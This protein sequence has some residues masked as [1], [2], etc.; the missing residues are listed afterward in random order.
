MLERLFRLREHGTTV[1]AE[2]QA[3]FAT[4]L[5]LAYI[6]IVNPSILS[7][8]GVPFEGALFATCVASA[9]ATLLMGV[10]ANYPFAL[11][12]GMGL[13]AYFAYSVVQ[14][15]GVPWQTALGAVF[16]SG[17][18]FVL[19]TVGR[20]RA[21]VVDAVP[22][23]LK[24]ATAAG[25][26]LFIAFIGLRNA[27]V[28]AASPATFVT[29]GQIA[30][31]ATLLSLAGLVLTA[32]LLARGERAA[33]VWGI[34]LVAAAAMALRLAPLPHGVVSL[35]DASATFLALDVRAALA[36]GLLDIVFVFLFVDLFDSVGT[37]MGLAQ[38]GGYLTPEGRL[39]RVNRA[40]LADG[41]GTVAGSLLGTST[42]TTYI[43]SAAG[44]SQGGRTG[45]VAVVVA[46]L[47]LLSAVLA[48]LAGAIP[49]MAT[50]PA[51][52]VV[53]ALMLRAVQEV[54]WTDMTEAAPAFLTLIAM[55]LTFSIAN[56]LA[57]GFITYPLIK[58]V[59]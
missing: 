36:L 54:P 2:V 18:L 5:T 37:F 23:S 35:P 53:G 34:L 17:V 40:L 8:A 26:G 24:T 45:L 46:L 49:P 15:L 38:Q 47:L 21:L 25:I 52:I 27:G 55:P 10:V 7:D 56:G 29:L 41:V 43:E 48:P 20:V 22:R 32:G 42:I 6:V 4:Y 33:I 9:A 11:A 44:I 59:S 58:L 31:P 1:R 3:G 13:N 50:A 57:L 16:L 51:L 39:P 14:G 19:L 28:I 12:P 30:A